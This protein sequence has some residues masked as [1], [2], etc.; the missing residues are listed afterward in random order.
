[1]LTH[2]CSLGDSIESWAKPEAR[3]NLEASGKPWKYEPSPNS[4]YPDGLPAGSRA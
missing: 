3:K 2:A 1:M 4:G